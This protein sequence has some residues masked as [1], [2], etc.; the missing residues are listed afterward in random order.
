MSETASAGCNATTSITCSS[1]AWRTTRASPRVRQQSG[2]RAAC[3][4]PSRP[5]STHLPRTESKTGRVPPSLADATACEN[6][7]LRGRSSAYVPF[8]RRTKRAVTRVLYPPSS[9][10]SASVTAPRH[11]LVLSGRPTVP[12]SAVNSR[13]PACV[14]A[15]SRVD[16]SNV[17][18]PRTSIA[19]LK[20]SARS[21][22]GGRV[23]RSPPRSS[24]A[25][26]AESD[27][28]LNTSVNSMPPVSS[29]TFCS[30][31]ASAS[32][33]ATCFA[34]RSKRFS[35]DLASISAVL[36]AASSCAARS[37]RRRAFSFC[38]RDA[39]SFLRR[40]AAR[41][42]SSSILPS[43][44]QRRLLPIEIQRIPPGDQQGSPGCGSARG[45]QSGA[46]RRSEG[47]G[48]EG[49][50][51]RRWERTTVVEA[52]MEERVATPAQ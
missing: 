25:R 27:A 5:G 1:P 40:E 18:G 16:S 23:T 10:S 48:R 32:S 22:E 20:S 36:R 37:L 39:C 41:S 17:I 43:A 44:A 51:K 7:S 38:T 6:A 52:E 28:A 45:A 26:V 9:H 34:S 50:T 15:P 35:V 30:R 13:T 29:R 24:A 4:T 46:G 12:S 19:P 2:W 21:A 14:R 11:T 8:G 31:S 47:G 49:G 33:A 3:S 42:N